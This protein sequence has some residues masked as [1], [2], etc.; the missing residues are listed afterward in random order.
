MLLSE[1]FFS[2]VI[3]TDLSSL[4]RSSHAEKSWLCVNQ[5]AAVRPLQVPSELNAADAS[6]MPRERSLNTQE[7]I[8]RSEQAS[9][10]VL[11]TKSLATELAYPVSASYHL[12]NDQLGL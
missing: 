12:R 5:C 7:A 11:A 9:M 3:V 6:N 10:P 4:A 1:A 2:N 8:R